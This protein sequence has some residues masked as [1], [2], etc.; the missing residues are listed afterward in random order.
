MNAFLQTALICSPVT[1]VNMQALLSFLDS[2]HEGHER[3]KQ[4]AL[5]SH[6]RHQAFVLCNF[7]DQRADAIHRQ[8]KYARNLPR[9]QRHTA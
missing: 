5:Q 7:S 6:Y 2:S 9:P 4:S 3:E 8:G 1:G